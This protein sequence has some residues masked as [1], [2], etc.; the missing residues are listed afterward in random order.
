MATAVALERFPQGDTNT[1]ESA[2]FRQRWSPSRRHGRNELVVAWERLEQLNSRAVPSYRSQPTVPRNQGAFQA[3][4][5]RDIRSIVGRKI[6]TQLPN[7]S[8]KQE[9]WISMNA[10]IKQVA[11][12]L[13][14]P[15]GSQGSSL[16]QTPQD[17]DYLEIEKMGRVQAFV[18]RIDSILDVAP[19]RGLKQ[20]VYCCRRI[21]DDHRAS[22]SS[23]TR[24]AVS[25]GA[26]TG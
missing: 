23:R 6:V 16:D 15:I 9:M 1:K 17:L 21:E 8:H 18:T 7:S 22:R 14:G 2:G 5:E 4:G 11:Y 20:P 25:M 12:G 10:E 3:F 26:V 13:I 19:R 24:R